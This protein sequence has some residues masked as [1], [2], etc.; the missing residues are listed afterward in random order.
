MGA[1]F[2][3]LPSRLCNPAGDPRSSVLKRHSNS[4]DGNVASSARPV[5]GQQLDSASEC[6][7]F[8]CLSS[9]PFVMSSMATLLMLYFETPV[10]S[11]AAFMVVCLFLAHVVRNSSSK[12]IRDAVSDTSLCNPTWDGDDAIISAYI[13]RLRSDLDQSRPPESSSELRAQGWRD[14]SRPTFSIFLKCPKHPPRLFVTMRGQLRDQAKGLP[15]VDVK[16]DVVRGGLLPIF[17]AVGQWPSWV[18]FCIGAR[19]IARIGPCKEMW[20]VRFRIALITADVVIHYAVIDRLKTAGCLDL[21]I[22]SPDEGME[23]KSWLGITVPPKT[24]QLR[25]AIKSFRITLK[26]K[27]ACDGLVEMQTEMVD[28][29]QI[30]WIHTLFWGTLGSH[31]L[32]IIANM[33]KQFSGSAIDRYYN[34]T[35]EVSTGA[36]TY[37]EELSR[38]VHAFLSSRD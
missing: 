2:D 30:E 1:C 38:A 33:H 11:C 34:G 17:L 19:L 31:C 13:H 24:A 15:L 16:Q 6:E 12:P 28:V 10:H 9:S 32:S 8:A 37:I 14:A 26:P 23:G 5:G 35:D 3:C 29:L 25:V 27:S 22:C 4:K 18:P 20:L 7:R 21:V 36:R